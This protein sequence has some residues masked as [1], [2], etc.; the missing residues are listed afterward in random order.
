MP[1]DIT[2][3]FAQSF[4]LLYPT[5]YMDQ[6]QQHWVSGIVI[7]GDGRSRVIGFPTANLRLEQEGQRPE[8][9]IYACWVKIQD[10][11]EIYRGVMHVGPRPT[12]PGALP[13]VEIHL[14]ETQHID[15]YTKTLHF[16]LVKRLRGVEKFNDL[17]ELAAA[18]QNDI[19]TAATYLHN[20]SSLL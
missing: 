7:Q 13:S 14:L 12:I 4:L 1:N 3:S 20:N 11:K 6:P 9:G 18:I 10:E 19:E 17:D 16:F 15:L 2:Q 8:D 5:L